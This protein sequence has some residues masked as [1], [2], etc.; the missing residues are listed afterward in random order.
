MEQFNLDI[1]RNNE[2]CTQVEEAINDI[3]LAKTAGKSTARLIYS[4]RRTNKAL[5]DHVLLL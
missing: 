5:Q 2:L 1:T 3:K 4:S